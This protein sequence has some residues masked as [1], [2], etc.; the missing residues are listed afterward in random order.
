MR[1]VIE[2]EGVRPVLK[3]SGTDT[4]PVAWQPG[5]LAGTAAY[6]RCPA[7]P[8][9]EKVTRLGTAYFCGSASTAR[10]GFVEIGYANDGAQTA[11]AQLAINGKRPTTLAF[12][13]TGG[14]GRVGAVTD[15]VPFQAGSNMLALSNADPS[16]PAPDIGYVINVGGP[17]PVASAI[18]TAH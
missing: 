14:D 15:Y 16:I 3:V 18:S 7:C 1:H 12:P 11:Y 17:V 5:L 10:G 9:G 8:G 2:R 4:V 6:S 13:P